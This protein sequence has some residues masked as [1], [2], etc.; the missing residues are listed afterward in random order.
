MNFIMI[1]Q[2]MIKD[3]NFQGQVF[4]IS[5]P[6]GVGKTTLVNLF[7]KK[8]AKKLKVA[9][10]VS[11]T[12]RGIRSNEIEGKDYYYIKEKEFFEKVKKGFFLEWVKW[13]DFYYGTP[14]VDLRNNQSYIFVVD[15][16]GAQAI[17]REYPDAITVWLYVSK[18]KILEERLR[19]RGTETEDNIKKRLEIA[20]K[21]LDNE[22]NNLTYRYR[23]KSANLRHSLQMLTAI[24]EQYIPPEN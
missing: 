1:R 17:L 8:F 7:L 10:V 9:R 12:T 18:I 22:K 2:A 3:S 11:Y 4:I 5:G 6:S 13:G 16:D 19:Q 24:V 20:R 15:K 21:E 14:R 23:I